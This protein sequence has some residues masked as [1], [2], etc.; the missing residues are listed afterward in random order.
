M[1]NINIIIKQKYAAS[2]IKQ[3]SGLGLNE[4]ASAR[5]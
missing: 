3:T 4:R 2:M 5:V 1:K